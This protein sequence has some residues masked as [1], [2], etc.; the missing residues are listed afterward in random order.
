MKKYLIVI[1]LLCAG[2]LFSI[3]IYDINAGEFLLNNT[4]SLQLRASAHYQ[5]MEYEVAAE[6][7]LQYLQN[8]T[9][10]VTSIYN[11]ACCYGLLDRDELAVYYL[12]IAIKKGYDDIGHINSDP[13]FDLIRDSEFFIIK[14]T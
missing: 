5:L 8:N 13:D 11:L 9:S 12:E 14:A 2:L 3:D 4:D 6:A 10:D 1:L 7:Y